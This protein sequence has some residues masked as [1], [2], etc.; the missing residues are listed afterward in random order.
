MD[1]VTSYSQRSLLNRCIVADWETVQER[2]VSGKGVLKVPSDGV[3]GRAFILF[4]TVVRKPPSPYL[5][6]NWN[7]PKSRYGTL[8]F[9]RQGYLIDSR[10]VEFEKQVWDGINDI[11]GQTLL[12]VKCA[13]DGI[14]ESFLNLA[15]GL[16]GTPGG[17]GLTTISVEDSIKDYE[18]LLL[19]W[20]EIR[21]QCYAD[22][23]LSLR[24]DALEYDVC[25][26]N[27][28]KKKK[29]P[30]PPDIPSVPS[31]TPVDVD[32]PYDDGNNDDG[33]TDPYPG[34]GFDPCFGV[35]YWRL[36]YL[37]TPGG[38]Q[39]FVIKGK[40]DDTFNL[41]LEAQ[42]GCK[43]GQKQSLY[44]DGIKVYDGFTC[45]SR[46]DLSSTA[47]SF[48]PVIDWEEANPNPRYPDC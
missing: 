44:S 10:A 35:G 4:C 30:P 14:L 5:N 28:N 33:N 39:Y 42:P 17:I 41:V 43:D 40:E 26:E 32:S 16:A 2:T 31:G 18:N 36:T 1:S 38:T 25:D 21:V 34:D 45:T 19:S 12:A 47:F 24:L 15:R 22:T 37:A 29:P 6:L 20:D 11:S 7:P 27:K 8:C 48:T 46:A 23:A 3:R 9:L 13:Y